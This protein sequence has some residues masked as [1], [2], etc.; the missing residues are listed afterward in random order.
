[1][2]SITDTFQLDGDEIASEDD[3]NEIDENLGKEQATALLT[4]LLG[5]MSTTGV[6][7]GPSTKTTKP[8]LSSSS[9]SKDQT[10]KPLNPA[11]FFNSEFLSKLSSKRSDENDE[12][13]QSEFSLMEPLLSNYLSYSYWL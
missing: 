7:V 8:T 2:S 6:G 11:S 4:K 1:M 12:L 10:E 9:A 3:D 5:D 13:S